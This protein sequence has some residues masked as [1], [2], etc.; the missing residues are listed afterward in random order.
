MPRIFS[1]RWPGMGPS[2]LLAL[3]LVLGTPGAASA[4]SLGEI[5]V[6]STLGEPFSAQIPLLPGP[7]ETGAEFLVTLASPE[8]YRMLEL[9]RPAAVAD[10]TVKLTPGSEHPRLVTVK[11]TTRLQ[12]PLFHLLIKGST[13]RGSQV[14]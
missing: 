14:R 4:F 12:E 7:G 6:S 13:G 2:T 8:E 5:R 3:T 1:Y 10:L 9:E 11:G